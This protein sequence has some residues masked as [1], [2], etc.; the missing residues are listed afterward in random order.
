MLDVRCLFISKSKSHYFDLSLCYVCVCLR[1]LPVM[2]QWLSALVAASGS[3]RPQPRGVP[4]GKCSKPVQGDW[5]LPRQ[6]KNGSP[7]AGREATEDPRHPS[8]LFA[9]PEACQASSGTPTHTFKT[10]AAER[11]Y[12]DHRMPPHL[13]PDLGPKQTRKTKRTVIQTI[14]AG[15][16]SLERDIG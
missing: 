9:L 6:G 7:P 5:V 11:N 2:C 8:P 12:T 13:R 1:P 14:F 10:V 3:I 4:A 16:V 15:T